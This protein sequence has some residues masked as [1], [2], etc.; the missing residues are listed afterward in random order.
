MR[1]DFELFVQN[2]APVALNLVRL[3]SSD[4]G[5][6]ARAA[7]DLL[8]QLLRKLED[9]CPR[10]V[11]RRAAQEAERRGLGDLRAYHYR[12]R[13]RLGGT[14]TFFW[15]HHVQVSDMTAKLL[16][17]RSPG[18][19]AVSDVMLTAKI[20]WLLREENHRLPPCPRVD[21]ELSYREARIELRHP[22]NEAWPRS[23]LTTPRTNPASGAKRRKNHSTS[24]VRL[25]R[26]KN[27][28][29]HRQL[30]IE[31]LTY[32]KLFGPNSHTHYF[33]L[34]DNGDLS[35]AQDIALPPELENLLVDRGQEKH[36]FLRKVPW[37]VIESEFGEDLSPLVDLVVRALEDKPGGW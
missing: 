7:K 32:S 15:E 23:A 27:A 18:L 11:S 10:N 5:P 9:E 16:K 28:F 6:T 35:V 22:W 37:R 13:R 3:A 26:L 21:P 33:I 30:R 34:E 1:Q 24:K 2:L 25:E 19:A 31:E 36:R 12:D 20:A 14:A 4:H 17:L 29:R 8:K